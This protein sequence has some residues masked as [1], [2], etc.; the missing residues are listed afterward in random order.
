MARS[1][2]PDDDPNKENLHIENIIPIAGNYLGG[3]TLDPIYTRLKETDSDVEGVQIELH[4]GYW[5]KRKQKAVINFECDKSRTGNEG[6]EGDA[7]G[8][9]VRGRDDEE[10]NDAN[11]LTFVSYG[12]VDGKEVTDVLRLNWKTKYACEDFVEEEGDEKKGGW[13]FFTWFILMYAPVSGSKD[14]GL[15]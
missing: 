10:G 9:T 8:R 11:S 6:K 4:G 1:W 3:G 14:E 2:N 13:G 12:S 15:C 5:D 7:K